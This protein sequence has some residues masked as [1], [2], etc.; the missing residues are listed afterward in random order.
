[1]FWKG[2]MCFLSS[3]RG[4]SIIANKGDLDSDDERWVEAPDVP[5]PTPQAFQGRGQKLG[6]ATSSGDPQKLTGMD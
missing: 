2:T 6:E 4:H 5:P 1:V 3:N